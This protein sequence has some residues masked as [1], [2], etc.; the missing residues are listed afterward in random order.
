MH[1]KNDRKFILRDHLADY[2]AASAFG[3]APID[4]RRV[5]GRELPFALGAS[6]Y[7]S[8]PFIEIDGGTLY[9]AA[10]V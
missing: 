3:L 7:V 10:F 9:S 6:A 5:L 1:N 8:V 2:V 4:K